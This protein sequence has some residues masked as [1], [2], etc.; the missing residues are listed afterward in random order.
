MPNP[1][2]LTLSLILA[3]SAALPA[4]AQEAAPHATALQT[5]AVPAVM[6]K[7]VDGFIRPGYR[8]FVDKAKA[9]HAGMDSLCA[10]PSDATL[11]AARQG[12]GDAVR[13]WARI[14]IIRVGPVIEENRFEH[15]LFYPDRKGL[16]LKQ[17][18]G[19]IASNDKSFADPQS[20][21]EKSVAIQGLGALEYVLYG[22]GAET[23]AQ[24]DGDFRCRY[25]AAI[26]GNV[27]NMAGE[28]S[29]LW[30]APGGVQAAWKQPGPDNDVFRTP[31][32]AVTGLLG[33]LVHGTETVRD[34]RIET[35]FKGADGRIAPKQ[36]I[37]W[38][39]GLTFVSMQE[40]LTGLKNLLN[41]TNAASLLPPAKRG[42]IDAINARADKLIETTKTIT[43]DVE[44]AVSKPDERQ[45]LVSL[46]DNSRSMITDLSDGLGGGVGLSAGFS[47]A[48]GD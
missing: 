44:A 34:E 8:Q 7:A 26:A 45:K 43:P 47:F 15:I 46:L 11:K 13:A 5:D 41:G 42:V 14:E 16:A 22:T 4:L 40:N 1:R 21:H 3:L 35:F 2:S 12:F 32:E 24:K 23:L 25:G 20:L 9:L 17:I 30:E 19:A 18:Q 36:A 10:T 27:E 37:F 6:E 29:S 39:S 33:V 38:R 28:L 48:D 31:S